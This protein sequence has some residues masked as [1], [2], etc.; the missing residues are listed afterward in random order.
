MLM[1]EGQA[2]L[3]V[4]GGGR[5]GALKVICQPDLSWLF[6]RYLSP[7]TISYGAKQ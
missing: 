3:L 6:F 1:D 7:E 2:I 5:I 4:R